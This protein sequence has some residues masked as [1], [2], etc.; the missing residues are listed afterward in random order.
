M[1]ILENQTIT[2]TGGVD[3]HLD[4]HVAAAIDSNGGVL[5][6]ETF[7]TTTGGYRQWI[8][9]IVTPATSWVS[10]PCRAQRSSH[11]HHRQPLPQ[12]APTPAQPTKP[13]LVNQT[14]SPPDIPTSFILITAE[15][16]FYVCQVAVSSIGGCSRRRQT[17]RAM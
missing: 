4:F 15:R 2:V 14:R 3:T 8:P 11:Q 12:R 1:T 16:V 10:L 9:T 5:G 6:V 7:D 17:R 13:Q